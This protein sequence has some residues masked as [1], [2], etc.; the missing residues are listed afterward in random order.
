[1]YDSIK[2]MAFTGFNDHMHVVG[3]D[4]PGKEAVAVFV[5]V[6]QRSFNHFSDF[7]SAK[8]TSAPAS[9]ES[10]IG[11]S[12][13]VGELCQGLSNSLGQAVGQAKRHELHRLRR[14]EVR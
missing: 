7:R 14:V 13:I 6:E 4:A 5:K 11:L 9:V 10:F 1:M 3:H 8:P 12:K 2:C